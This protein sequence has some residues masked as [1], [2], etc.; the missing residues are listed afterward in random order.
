MIYRIIRSNRKT[1]AIQIKPN[2]EIVVRAPRWLGE[3]EIHKFVISKENWIRKHLEEDAINYRLSTEDLKN[4]KKAALKVIPQRV[5]YYASIIGVTYGRVTIRSQKTR[6]GSC[7]AE[8]NLNFN[9]LL[10]MTPPEVLDS[11][12]VHE[13]C[14]RKQMN[15]SKRFYDEVYRVFPD[16]DKWNKW[17]KKNGRDLIKKI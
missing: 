4:L 12:V 17:L 7:S 14:H 6:W 16:Y 8:G 10:M 13:L 5:Q 11:V 1:L 3:K 2:N 15:H 9:C